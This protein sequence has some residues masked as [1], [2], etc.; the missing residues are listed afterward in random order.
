M[1]PES[2]SQSDCVSCLS[3][4]P[5]T[6]SAPPVPVTVE[7][8]VYHRRTLVRGSIQRQKESLQIS[9][10]GGERSEALRAHHQGP[11]DEESLQL[12]RL[13]RN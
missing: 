3:L 8:H 2:L 1:Q 7:I 13:N 9:G 11:S 6:P 10:R 12:Y 4:L 5:T